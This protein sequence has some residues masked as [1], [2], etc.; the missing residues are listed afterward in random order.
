MMLRT[1]KTVGNHVFLILFF[2]AA[3]RFEGHV[4][5][6]KRDLEEFLQPLLGNFVFTKNL[7]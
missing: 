1:H 7:Q 6:K 5:L 2:Q 3:E 4:A